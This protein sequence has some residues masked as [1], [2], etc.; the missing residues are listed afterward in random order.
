MCA[1]SCRLY[2]RAVDSAGLEFRSDKLWEHYITWESNNGNMAAITTIYDR[3]LATPTQ[4]YYQNWE[5]FKRHV[6]EHEVRQVTRPEEFLDIHKEV[7]GEPVT[8]SSD[9]VTGAVTLKSEDTP[10][11]VEVQVKKEEV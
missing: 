1:F 11:G 5:N 3:L 9:D 10:P 8:A 2:E 6:E 4:M 7:C